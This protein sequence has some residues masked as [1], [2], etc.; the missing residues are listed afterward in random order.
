MDRR[1]FLIQSGKLVIGASVSNLGLPSRAKPSPG[2]ALPRPAPDREGAAADR[3]ITLF[4]AGDVMTGRGIDQILPHPVDPRLYESYIKNAKAYVELA[5]RAHGP[6][7]EEV[8]HDYI[9]GDALEELERTSPDLRLVNLETAVTTSNEYWRG[10]EVHYRM[11]PRNT[12]CLTAAGIDC[13]VLA[14]NHVL[15]WGYAGLEETRRSL[16]TAGIKTAGAGRNLEEAQ[17]PA[18]FELPSRKRVLVF[19][20]GSESSGI[21]PRWAAAEDRP[22]VHLIDESSPGAASRVQQVVKRFTQPG[23]LVVVSIHWGSNW[24][25]EIPRDQQQFAHDLIDDAGVDV[26]HGHS[27]HHIKAIEMYRNKPIL[28]G[29]GDFLTDYEG[30]GGFEMF[31]G[32]LG[33]MYFVSMGGTN[34]ELVNLEMRP[35]QMKRLQVKHASP[36]DAAWLAEVHNRE[37]KKFGTHVELADR[38]VLTLRHK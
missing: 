32:D 38:D 2:E 27:S 4:L 35:T 3:P 14:N 37:G 17:H 22:G 25:Y 20:V 28:Y 15:D 19:A 16:E 10:K 30:I 6:I 33:L 18:V 1:E 13:C 8:T 11:H 24:G 7:P 29:C 12:P 21:P 31:R 23:D 5:E 9:W 26:V 36:A 34:Q